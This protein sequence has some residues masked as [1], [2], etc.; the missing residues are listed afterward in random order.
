MTTG[1]TFYVQTSASSEMNMQHDNTAAAPQTTQRAAAAAVHPFNKP[2]STQVDP[3]PF[4]ECL[5]DMS[6]GYGK[7]TYIS[8]M[9]VKKLLKVQ[10]PPNAKPGSTIHVRIPG[11]GD[12]V[13][14]AQVP[15]NCSEFHVQYDTKTAADPESV[16][17]RR[18]NNSPLLRHYTS[19]L[20]KAG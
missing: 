8:Q 3:I 20:G 2:Q 12:R 15:P 5:D 10:V 16:I 14:A 7:A 13:L 9:R 19:T 1:S 11:E 4:A 6:D 17:S 18:H